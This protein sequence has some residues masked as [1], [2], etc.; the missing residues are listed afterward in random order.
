MDILS[1]T[2][3]ENELHDKLTKVGERILWYFRTRESER[4]YL[5]LTHGRV[6]K[7]WWWLNLCAKNA[8]KFTISYEDNKYTHDRLFKIKYNDDVILSGKVFVSASSMALYWNNWWMFVTIDLNKNTGECTNLINYEPKYPDLVTQKDLLTILNIVSQELDIAIVTAVQKKTEEP[9]VIELHEATVN[10]VIGSNVINKL[11]DHVFAFHGRQVKLAECAAAPSKYGLIDPKTKQIN[12]VAHL[13]YRAFVYAIDEINKED[14]VPISYMPAIQEMTWE[15]L[16]AYKNHD[17]DICLA[18]T[19]HIMRGNVDHY[20][21]WYRDPKG[22]KHVFMRLV[23]DNPGHITVYEGDRSAVTHISVRAKVKVKALVDEYN[24]QKKPEE[25]EELKEI[26]KEHDKEVLSDFCNTLKEFSEEY[27]DNW[28]INKFN[29]LIGV[30]KTYWS[31][32]NQIDRYKKSTVRISYDWSYMFNRNLL[33]P[34]TMADDRYSYDYNPT[35]FKIFDVYDSNGDLMVKV[36]H[37]TLEI[38]FYFYHSATEPFLT[39]SAID[40]MGHVKQSYYD[41]HGHMDKVKFKYLIDLIKKE[42]NIQIMNHFAVP[43]I[44]D[45]TWKDTNLVSEIIEGSSVVNDTWKNPDPFNTTNFRGVKKMTFAKLRTIVLSWI[46]QNIIGDDIYST[47]TTS[48]DEPG[49]PIKITVTEDGTEKYLFINFYNDQTVFDIYEGFFVFPNKAITI[50]SDEKTNSQ[51]VEIYSNCT[52]SHFSRERIMS[53]YNTICTEI[54]KE[55]LADYTFTP[56]STGTIAI[57]RYGNMSISPRYEVKDSFE[58]ADGSKVIT[59]LNLLGMSIMK[60]KRDKN[61]KG[62]SVRIIPRIK[63]ILFNEKKK[64]TTII[65]NDDTKTMAKCTSDDDYDEELGVAICIAKKYYGNNQNQM[66]KE[67][68]KF[69]TRQKKHETAVQ[70][71]LDKKNKVTEIIDDKPNEIK[72]DDNTDNIIG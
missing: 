6:S 35:T 20:E 41:S 45:D 50:R 66:R 14:N 54:R 49:I 36:D 57:N 9:K 21:L 34:V 40:Y 67:I 19:E 47:V 69:K 58:M 11:T 46:S 2:P 31:E 65:W 63:S 23:V 5:S 62:A 30:L 38:N 7:S 27:A 1:L 52:F 61:F 33:P 28:L 64:V 42:L 70:K 44:K 25:P 43:V 32:I 4:T 3:R 22:I 8:A 37:E 16:F 53:L 15:W 68:N 71:R 39:I 13:I 24:N 60:L 72:V 12:E 56:P 10:D 18:C 51:D 26:A 59:G 48:H 55:A 17:G 29:K